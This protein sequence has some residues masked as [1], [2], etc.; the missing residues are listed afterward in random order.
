VRRLDLTGERFGKLVAIK[1]LPTPAHLK[2]AAVSIWRC[3]CDC[4]NTITAR[5]GNLRNGHTTSC[6][7]ARRERC[8]LHSLRHGHTSGRTATRTFRSW[9]HAKA[10]CFTKTD[11]KYPDYGGRGITM[12]DAW[13]SDFMNFLRDMG[14]CPEGH[15]IDRINND[16]NYEPGN[17]RWATPLE[18]ARNKRPY[19]N[20]RLA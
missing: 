15:S 10:R 13:R 12:C 2:K 6:G 3:R 19:K 20:R 5:M 7:C 16:G 1:K 9:S 17:C 14:E 18:Q 11:A 8:G 4:G